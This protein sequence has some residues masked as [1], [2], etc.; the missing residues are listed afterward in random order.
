MCK[1]EIDQFKQFHLGSI[2]DGPL[3]EISRKTFLAE[4]LDPSRLLYLSYRPPGIF[5]TGKENNLR[6]AILFS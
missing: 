1:T 3:F 6:K 5:L 2:N 4:L